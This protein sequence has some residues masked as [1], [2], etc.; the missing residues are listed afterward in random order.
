MARLRKAL[1]ALALADTSW[2]ALAATAHAAQRLGW[3]AA[4][5]TAVVGTTGVFCFG[6]ALLKDAPARNGR[7]L[8][9]SL[10]CGL[11]INLTAP[12]SGLGFSFLLVFAAPFRTGL[13]PAI[14]I[15]VLGSGCTWLVL[16]L[17]RL[18][19]GAVIGTGLGLIYFAL[20]GHLTWYAYSGRRQAAQVAEAR[21]G[22]AVLQERARLAR[23][24]HDV[25]AHSQSAQIVHLQGAR[26]L[27]ERGGPPSE[28]L[29]RLDR[30]VRLARTGLEETRRAL[31]TLRGQELPL[32]E[33][34]ERLAVEFRSVTGTPCEVSVEGD[35][36][37]LPAGA[38]LA[39]ARTAQEALTNARKHAPGAAVSLALRRLGPWC[40]LEVRDDGTPLGRRRGEAEHGGYG[41]VGM[42]ERAELIGGSLEAGPGAAGFSVR[43]RVP[44]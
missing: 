20:F 32:P 28:V 39:V 10:A 18:P 44:V 4:L 16:H 1:I 43:L 9:V 35:V 38:R 21:A 23:E 30:A 42:R 36:D 11:A 3:P 13:R 6:W 41:L 17:L 29:D 25:L 15:S 27:L 2:C 37:T 33:R 26:L 5:A 7:L 8:V 22:E 31:D 40:E 19:P 12:Y 34:L 24:I 14:A